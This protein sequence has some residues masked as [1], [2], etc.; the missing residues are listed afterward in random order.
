M[1]IWEIAILKAIHQ[2][3]GQA[4]LRQLYNGLHGMIHL[5]PNHLKA[6]VHGGRP[7]YQHQVRSHVTNLCQADELIWVSRG[8]YAITAK[9]RARLARLGR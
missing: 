5:T 4:T 9:G 3:G 1:N 7:A 6:T 2:L 8:C